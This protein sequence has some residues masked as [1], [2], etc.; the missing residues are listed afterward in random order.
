MAKRI[1]VLDGH[2][3]PAP[4]RLV[5]ALADVYADAARGG[6]HEVRCVRLAAL[7]FPVLRAVEDWKNGPVPESLRDA[8]AALGWADHVV[9]LFPLW[10]GTLP[11]LTKAFLEQ[12]ARPNFAFHYTAAGP[13]PALTGKT[14]RVVVTMGMPAFAYRWF[15]GAHGVRGLER[16]VLNFVGIKPVRTTYIGMVDTPYFKAP[17][18]FEKMRELGRRGE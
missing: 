1:L 11:A 18:W 16:N 17:R 6:G 14:A 7:E 3:D 5:H 10:T 15:Y 12:V 8:Q 13:K 4:A 9:L 2:P